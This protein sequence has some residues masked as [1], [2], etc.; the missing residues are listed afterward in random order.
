MLEFLSSNQGSENEG[1]FLAVDSQGKVVAA[2][3]STTNQ[4]I[5][6]GNT[7]PTDSFYQFW[8][9]TSTA[10]EY[11]R[12]EYVVAEGSQYLDLGFNPT[13][14]LSF[15]IDAKITQTPSTQVCFAGAYETTDTPRFAYRVS[16][17]KYA[18]LWGTLAEISG[19]LP[20]GGAITDRRVY[21]LHDGSFYYGSSLLTTPSTQTFTVN[22]TLSVLCNHSADSYARW[23]YANVYDIILTDS[24][25][26]F[27]FVPCY[28][29]SDNVIGFYDMEGNICPQTNTPFWTSFGNPFVTKGPDVANGLI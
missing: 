22:Q 3:G 9:D 6:I 18:I 15:Y 17:T 19:N 28:R 1:K 11:Q 4:V 7:A 20:S 13:N 16:G 21:S 23:I 24:N 25:K 5:Y 29:L 10:P 12:V 27:H 14:N 8:L 26:S 2:S